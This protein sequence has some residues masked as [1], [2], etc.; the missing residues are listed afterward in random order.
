MPEHNTRQASIENLNEVVL[1]LTQS[2]HFLAQNHM[3]LTQ[4]Q[5]TM[6]NK[7][8]SVL[9]HLATLTVTLTP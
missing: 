4:A 8:D 1:R 9:Q 2:Q 5:P 3:N 7:I 6:D